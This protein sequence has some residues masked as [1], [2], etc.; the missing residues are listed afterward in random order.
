VSLNSANTDQVQATF[1]H[2]QAAQAATSEAW[3]R[4]T[5]RKISS[6]FFAR[7]IHTGRQATKV[8]FCPVSYL[9]ARSRSEA[10]TK[11][12]ITAQ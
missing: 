9:G 4:L 6:R 10:W 3:I 2:W 11:R 8:I 12:R 1:G 5:A 7:L